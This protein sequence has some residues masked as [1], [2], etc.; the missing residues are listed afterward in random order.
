[1]SSHPQAVRDRSFGVFDALAET[2]SGNRHSLMRG[3]NFWVEWVESAA[4][5]VPFGL[6]SD[7]ESLVITAATALQVQTDG[8]AHP[9]CGAAPHPLAGGGFLYRACFA[10]R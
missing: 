8:V 1:M 5:G 10:A 3:Q 2:R 4:S 6:H 9:A 7:C